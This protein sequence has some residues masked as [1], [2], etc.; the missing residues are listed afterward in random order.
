MSSDIY[1]IET[2]ICT[3]ENSL[4][5]D[6]ESEVLQEA[7]KSYHSDRIKILTHKEETLHQQTRVVWLLIGDENSRYFHNLANK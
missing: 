2:D 3:I 4:F 6:P 7:L 5:V 1:R